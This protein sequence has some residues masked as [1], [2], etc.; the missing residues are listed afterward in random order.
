MRRP[1]FTPPGADPNSPAVSRR[2][3]SPGGFTLIEL[4][5]VIAIIA[6]LA[7]FL[8]PVFAQV[9]GAARTT[10]C[11]SNLKQLGGA[12]MMYAQDN[13]DRY[14]CGPYKAV[15]GSQVQWR[16]WS[17]M[18]FTYVR[19]KGL[20]VCPGDPTATDFIRFT[21]NPPE[22]GG[23]MGGSMGVL[24]GDY[25]YVGYAANRAL[26]GQSTTQSAMPPRAAETSVLFDSY[27]MCSP[28]PPFTARGTQI[29][30]PTG[31]LRHHVGSCGITRV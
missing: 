14:P 1:G 9:R 2:G 7:G 30:S 25:Q 22:D 31:K 15:I 20:Y 24:S 26:F 4:L 3:R 19:S 28:N 8:F 6:I 11:L 23:C 16:W 21:G 27:P 13:D 10:V 5:V 17:D 18:I 29:A 12:V